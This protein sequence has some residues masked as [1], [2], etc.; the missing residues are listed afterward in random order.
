[1]WQRSACQHCLD[2]HRHEAKWL[3]F[4]DLDEHLFNPTCASLPQTLERF[5]AHPGVAV[6]WLYFGS[7]GRDEREGL[8]VTEALTRRASTRWNRDHRSPRTVV[9]CTTARTS[10]T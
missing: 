10:R 3:A 8:L 7:S 2:T 5:E 1:V 6:N 9:E 4:I